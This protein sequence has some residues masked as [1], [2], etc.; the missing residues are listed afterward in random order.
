MTADDALK[1]K[2]ITDNTRDLLKNILS[3]KDEKNE[4]NEK[5]NDEKKKDEK[6]YAIAALRSLK[7]FAKNKQNEMDQ[8]KIVDEDTFKKREGILAMISQMM[9]E[10]EQQVI[11]KKLFNIMDESGDGKLEVKELQKGW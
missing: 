4:R 3:N 7:E 6:K 5:K 1:D 11:I 2:F 9:M 10:D 8:S